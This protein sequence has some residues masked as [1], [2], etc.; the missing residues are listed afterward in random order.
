MGELV[1]TLR[2]GTP[3]YCCAASG[4]YNIGS[5]V[6][7]VALEVCKRDGINTAACGEQGDG[8]VLLGEGRGRGVC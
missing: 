5:V 8:E 2:V 7:G 1:L 6:V 3:V 4:L